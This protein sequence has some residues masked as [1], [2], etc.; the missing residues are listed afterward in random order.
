MNT[1]ILLIIFNRPDT[2]QMVFNEIKKQRPKYLF[3]AA[4]GP[5]SDKEGEFEKCQKTREIIKQIDWDCE[6]KTLF[7][8]VN[9]G[10]KWNIVEA[11]NWMFETEEYGIILEDDCVAATSFFKFCVDTLIKFKN[12]ES[13][14]AISGTNIQSTT[15]V[16]ADYFFSMMGGNWGWAT[17]KRAWK[18]FK[19]DI[20]CL[21]TIEN[22]KII[23][24]NSGHPK[25]YKAIRTVIE[26]SS[27]N[28][29]HDTWDYQWLFIRFLLNK[30]SVV[31]KVNLVKNIGFSTN[32]THTFSESHPL[33]NLPLYELSFPIS[34]PLK[35]EPF[36]QYDKVFAEIF[37]P[38]CN[39][40]VIKKTISFF[41]RMV[42]LPF[43][44]FGK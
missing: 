2:T 6:L 43:R 21:L 37:C 30:K 18:F 11:I 28:I 19:P 23:K 40:L 12:D 9:L 16:G 14:F 25:V 32:S 20:N 5:R 42:L 27:L 15:T 24:K 7:R 31:P 29:E 13:I 35:C 17:W 1:P 44:M 10:C 4:D 38:W 36:I 41:K 33:S 8:D 34:H 26:S 22:W 39:F 3:V